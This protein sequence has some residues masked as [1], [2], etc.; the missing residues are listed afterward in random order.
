MKTNALCK[1]MV[2]YFQYQYQ[3]VYCQLKIIEIFFSVAGQ[4]PLCIRSFQTAAGGVEKPGAESP[5]RGTDPEGF[6]PGG[7][8]HNPG[9]NV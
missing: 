9:Q 7:A 1:L 6:A 2:Q 5:G 4:R 8:G 3:T